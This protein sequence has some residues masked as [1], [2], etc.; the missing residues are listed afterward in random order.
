L[1]NEQVNSTHYVFSESSLSYAFAPSEWRLG[2]SNSRKE[3]SLK[4]PEIAD[5]SKYPRLHFTVFIP[6]KEIS[7]LFIK[8]GADE[9]LLNILE[10][11]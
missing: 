7:P 5:D 9:F 2:R 11:F 4:F 8:K 6:S 1:A 3:N 10:N